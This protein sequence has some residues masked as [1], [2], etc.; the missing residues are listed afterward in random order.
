MR[1]VCPIMSY[2]TGGGFKVKCLREECEIFKNRRCAL[3]NKKWIVLMC[4]TMFASSI[5]LGLAVLASGHSLEL[6]LMLL[7]SVFVSHSH[8]KD[9]VIMED[10]IELRGTLDQV[11]ERVK[12]PK[13]IWADEMDG[14]LKF[15][16]IIDER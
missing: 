13:R 2:R 3:N 4:V 16:D 8:H 5:L 14:G 15:L 6:R 11:E 10:Y 1:K 7:E 9:M 12:V